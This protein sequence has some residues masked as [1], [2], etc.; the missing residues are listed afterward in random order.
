MQN[1]PD[2]HEIAHQLGPQWAAV[3]TNNCAS[4]MRTFDNLTLVFDPAT[5]I[6]HS[7]LTPHRYL[8]ANSAGE[9]W[10]YGATEN[11]TDIICAPD[12]DAAALAE[13]IKENLPKLNAWW[14]SAQ[15]EAT[16]TSAQRTLRRER[17][18]ILRARYPGT[19]TPDPA[20][21]YSAGN[22]C[23]NCALHNV[24]PGKYEA[25][26][27]FTGTFDQVIDLIDLYH[28]LNNRPI[29]EETPCSTSKNCKP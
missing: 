23:W 28:Q 4:L 12:D 2:L 16:A 20:T 7:F 25:T 14:A 27:T 24:Q 18:S 26:V 21:C 1:Q 29:N 17:S 9:P 5:T 11:R 19:K 3:Q 13:K 8:G 6:N 15:A 22:D 10:H